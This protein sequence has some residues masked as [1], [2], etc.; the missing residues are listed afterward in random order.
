VSGADEGSGTGGAP[1]GI[2]AFEVGSSTAVFRLYHSFSDLW[3]DGTGTGNKRYDLT[4]TIALPNPST[5]GDWVVLISDTHS[6]SAGS[7][8]AF[9]RIDGLN[10]GTRG[11]WTKDTSYGWAQNGFPCTGRLKHLVVLGDLGPT[12]V[13]RYG[14]AR[15]DYQDNIWNTSGEAGTFGVT[16]IPANN[17]WHY[18]GNHDTTKLMAP[19]NP[20]NPG[21]PGFETYRLN[22]HGRTTD[23]EGNA[24]SDVSELRQWFDVGNNRFL[25]LGLLGSADVPHSSGL[26]LAGWTA[27]DIAWATGAID[28]VPG[29]TNLFVLPH[30]PMTQSTRQSWENRTPPAVDARLA[31]APWCAA[32]CGHTHA[33]DLMGPDSGSVGARQDYP[34]RSDWS[35]GAGTPWPVVPLPRPVRAGGRTVRGIRI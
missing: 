34:T 24:Y 6:G 21:N 11:R 18:L 16:S 26:N 28:A 30:A 1:I 35:I 31:R 14:T 27:G 9:G 2:L 8:A 5:T 25:L 10:A 17:T 33:F 23:T 13:N 22:Q 3:W 29:A 32:F 19:W 4:R 12:D 7:K 20:T 15:N